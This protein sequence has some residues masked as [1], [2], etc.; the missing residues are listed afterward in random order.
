MGSLIVPHPIRRGGIGQGSFIVV[1]SN[2]YSPYFTLKGEQS[3]FTEL[4]QR[5]ERTIYS[6]EKVLLKDIGR[7]I[8]IIKCISSCDE[9][10]V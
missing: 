1:K 9:Q 2:K 6:K 7:G 3:L 5:E 8:F 4:N 10:F